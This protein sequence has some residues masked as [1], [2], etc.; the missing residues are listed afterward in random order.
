MPS[1]AGTVN[2][3]SSRASKTWYPSS[4]TFNA[5]SSGTG[6]SYIKASCPTTTA[7]GSTSSGNKYTVCIKVTT[8]SSSSISSISAIS[9]SFYCKDANTTAGT[10]YGSLRTVAPSTGATGSDTVAT[11]NSTYIA[12]SSSEQSLSPSSSY[13]QCTMTF[14]GSFSKNTSYY[15]YLYTKSTNDIYD[16]SAHSSYFTCSVTYTA[17]SYT[18]SYNA[19]GHGTAPSSQT[20]SY[21]TNITL[22]SFISNVAGTGYT[23][24]Y[25]A[26]GGSSTPASH[27]ASLTYTQTSW[28][29]N[30]SGTGTSY[31]SGAT[32]SSNASATLYAIWSSTR[33]SVTLKSAIT[34]AN[35]TA[36][37]TITYNAN[38]GS[39]TPSQQTLTRS[40]PYTF[41]GWRAGSTSGTLYSA[42]ATFKPTANTTMY[43][44]WTSGTTTGSVNLASAINKASSSGTG[45]T[46]TLDPD[47][48]SCSQTTL[49]T[50]GTTTYTFK[51]WNTNANGTGTAYSAGASYS[52]GAD[53]TLYAIFNSASTG[54]GSVSLPTPKKSGYVFLGWST[55]K[56]ST[57]YVSQDYTPTQNVTL[58]A[59]YRQGYYVEMYL[60]NG[61]RWMN[62]NMG[63]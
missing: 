35:G 15:L 17:V 45:Y 54:G 49:T 20:K 28:N 5:T 24:S 39:S 10:L 58:Y 44:S 51:E 34:R 37:Y 38:G 3:W 12:G 6:A 29:T 50:A 27:T 36:S 56:G 46:V 11:L 40:T 1:M 47:G 9:I 21:G 33:G 8:P 19:N 32:Y 18:I 23:V 59:N 26:N 2:G 57:S 55:T 30:S 52:T 22:R 31:G 48:G 62:V 4:S 25:N 13:A 53:L 43:A 41:A 7:T 16:F 42:G 60:F 61:G 14:S 63:N